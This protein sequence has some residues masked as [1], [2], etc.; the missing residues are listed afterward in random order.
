MPASDL[1]HAGTINA[2][3]AQDRQ[4]LFARPATTALNAQ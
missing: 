2:D 3:L 1:A 4:L